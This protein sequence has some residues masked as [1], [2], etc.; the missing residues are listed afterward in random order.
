MRFEV[1]RTLDAIEARLSLDQAL[2]RG[3]LDLTEVVRL[4]D[5]ARDGKPASLLRLGHV[6]DALG[7]H[8]AEDGVHVYVVVDRALLSDLDLTS[9]ERMVI[10]RW[11]DDGRVEVLPSPPGDRVLEVADLLGV[12]VLSRRPYREFADRYPWLPG[13]LL[14]PTAGGLSAAGGGGVSPSPSP[15]LTRLWRCGEFDC[16]GFGRPA[17]GQPPPR[18][19][20]GVPTCP[21]HEVQLADAGP[22]PPARVVAVQVDGAVR[23]R[24]VVREAAPALVGRAPAT[25]VALGPWLN[26]SA[27]RWVSRSHALLEL[28]GAALVVTD[29]STNGTTVRTRTGP[30]RLVPGQPY[31]LAAEDVVELSEGVLLGRP[32]RFRGGAAQ[33]ASVM[34]EAPTIALRPPR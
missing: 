18:M 16:V 15:M 22:R 12:P 23:C 20:A 6:V 9:N 21:R 14:V 26:E 28:R 34:A 24:F 25:G 4:P 7:R 1:S 31:G 3:V 30:V 10:R 13:G 17:G 19:R 32:D 2:A 11:A 33:P 5:L 27:L 29:Q 8:L